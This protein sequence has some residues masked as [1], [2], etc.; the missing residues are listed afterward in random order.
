MTI[1]CLYKVRYMI[2]LAICDDEPG[3][4]ALLSEYIHRFSEEIGEAIAITQFDSGEA[5]L[6]DYPADCDIILI[7]I[8]MNTLNGIKTAARIRQISKDVCII[9]ITQTPQYALNAYKVH[10]LGYL[11][12]PV[13]YYELSREMKE[14]LRRISTNK[15]DYIILKN[16]DGTT[17]INIQDIIYIEAQNHKLQIVL[18]DHEDYQYYGKMDDIENQLREKD[19]FRCH[20]AYILNLRWVKKVDGKYA[21]LTDNCSVPVSKYRYQDLMQCLTEFWGKQL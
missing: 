19:F 16:Q 21:M 1:R 14:A 9:F 15:A 11:T 6:A 3:A 12:K 20:R 13:S 4:R 5:L 10:A 8:L 2:K 17:R 7:D 18:H